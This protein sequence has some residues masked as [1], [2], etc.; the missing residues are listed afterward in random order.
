MVEQIVPILKVADTARAV[1]WYGRLGFT[2]DFEH[3]YSEDFPG[4]VGISRDGLAMHLSEHVGDATPD[5]LVYIFVAD[6]DALAAEFGVE[7]EEQSWA[8]DFEVTDPDGNRIRVGTRVQA[9]AEA[10]ASANG[11]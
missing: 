4:Y 8:R 5:T 3:R 9:D 1:E 2:K 11:S 10:S 6:V 7:V